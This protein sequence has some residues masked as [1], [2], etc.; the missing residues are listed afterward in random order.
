V[1]P[2]LV[3]AAGWLVA[4]LLHQRLPFEIAGA[5]ASMPQ[6][7]IGTGLL[8]VGLTLMIWVPALFVRNRT[9]IVPMRGAR[10]LVTSGP[11]RYTRNPMYL[12]MTAAYVGLAILVNQAWPLLILPGVLVLL[13]LIV[14]RREERHLHA[15]FPDGYAVYCRRVR[16]WL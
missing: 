11:F 4:W 9:P 10:V 1:P 16:R 3:F 15:V 14:I 13:L 7:A 2:P 5:G 6:Q 8:A 12:G